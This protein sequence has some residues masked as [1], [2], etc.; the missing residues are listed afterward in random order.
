M[1]TILLVIAV[2]YST[3][4]FSQAYPVSQTK[5]EKGAVPRDHMIYDMLLSRDKYTLNEVDKLYRTDVVKRDTTHYFSNMQNF[6]FLILMREDIALDKNGTEEQKKYYVNE[7]LK[8]EHTLPTHQ[9]FYT[10]LLSCSDFMDKDEL[11]QKGNAFYEKNKADIE[12]I[13]WKDSSE[14]YGKIATLG[15]LHEEFI[16]GV[17]RIKD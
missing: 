10:L 13:K 9:Q 17:M 2:F 7:M 3:V 15:L 4:S 1:K 12:K 8:A 11:L 16:H 5:Q 6:A 14:E